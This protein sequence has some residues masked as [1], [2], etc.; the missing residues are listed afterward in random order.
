MPYHFAAI[1]T[2]TARRA[3]RGEPDANGQVPELQTSD[4]NGNPCRHC[5]RD[6]PEGAGML[7]MAHRPFPAPQPYAEIGPIFLCAE[8]CPRHPDQA[9]LPAL[10][11]EYAQ[12]LIRGYGYNDRIR[13]GSGKVVTIDA[14][15]PALDALFA[16]DTI[17]YIHMRS[18]TNNCF[19]CRVERC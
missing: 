2:E 6:I 8:A 4:G 1:D 14:L 12:I 13:Y 9:A 10:F 3:Q 11:Q 15:S 16:D 19:Q 18:A 5:L 7:V 17:A